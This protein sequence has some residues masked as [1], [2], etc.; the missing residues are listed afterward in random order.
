[1]L[2]LAQAIPN[3][4]GVSAFT[5][6]LSEA[7]VGKAWEPSNETMLFLSPTP[8]RNKLPRT[9]SKTFHFHLFFGFQY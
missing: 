3:H 5:L 2:V 9:F 8:S 7:R 6:R 1:M 4:S